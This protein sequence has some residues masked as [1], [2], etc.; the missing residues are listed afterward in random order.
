LFVSSNAV[1]TSGASHAF[2]VQAAD[3]VPS[4]ASTLQLPPA[5]GS[6]RAGHSRGVPPGYYGAFVIDPTA[7]NIEAVFHGEADR[8][9]ASVVVTFNE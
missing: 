7:N 8:S 6:W 4:S 3:R 9:A 5:A 2:G 1:A